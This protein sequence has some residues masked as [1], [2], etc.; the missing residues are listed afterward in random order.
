[1]FK[2][3]E[4]RDDCKRD[5]ECDYLH[6]NLVNERKYQCVSCKDAWD[7]GSCMV[8]PIIQNT[9]TFFCLNC[10]EWVRN[11]SKVLEEGRTLLDRFGQLRMEL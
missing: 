2:W 5:T 1:M 7:D 3:N 10:D 4:G 11:K 9:S 8:E 6:V